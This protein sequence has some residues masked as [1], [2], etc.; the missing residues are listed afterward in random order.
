[1]TPAEK[2][3]ETRKRHREAQR[4]AALEGKMLRARLKDSCLSILNDKEST[5]KERFR[6]TEILYELTKGR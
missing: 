6:A 1:M 2:A 4:Q 5:R 3:R